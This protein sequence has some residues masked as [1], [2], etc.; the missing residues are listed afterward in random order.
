MST[1]QE[2]MRAATAGLE[3]STLQEAMRAATAGAA[4]L[5]TL[6][7]A[8]RAAT[9]GL[10]MS[11]LQEAMRTATA[12]MFAT[13]AAIESLIEDDLAP[14]DLAVPA[15]IR[16][17]PCESIP[18]PLLLLIVLLTLN[19]NARTLVTQF[20]LALINEALLVA[21]GLG[22]VMDAHPKISGALALLGL[23]SQLPKGPD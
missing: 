6:Q 19:A 2:A 17:E 18:P 20:A 22:E 23:W 13:Q 9:A 21:E 1:L 11:T 3:M 15:V 14:A 10:E 12:T 5:S 16:D 4:G 8:T 7:E